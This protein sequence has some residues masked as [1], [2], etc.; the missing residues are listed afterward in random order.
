[1]SAIKA[2]ATTQ[3][4]LCPTLSPLELAVAPSMWWT[5]S[6]PGIR[7]QRPLE[8]A[9]RLTTEVAAI[10]CSRPDWPPELPPAL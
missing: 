10:V 1:L 8:G 3:K 7:S 9:Y 5:P 4:L 2:L 6:A